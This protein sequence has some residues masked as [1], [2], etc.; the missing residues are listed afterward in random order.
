MPF[1]LTIL[2]AAAALLLGRRLALNPWTAGA[3]LGLL[4]C[5]LVV[6]L[7]HLV[8][9]TERLAALQ[10]LVALSAG[11]LLFGMV[12]EV[13]DWLED[14]NGMGEA[15][16]GLGYALFAGVA[17]FLAAYG[18]LPRANLVDA[19]GLFLISFG[20]LAPDPRPGV[21]TGRRVGSWCAALLVMAV[22][23]LLPSPP[24]SAGPLP[25][26]A[27]LLAVPLGLAKPS[28][29]LAG[30]TPFLAG[31][32]LLALATGLFRLI[33]P[34]LLGRWPRVPW[35]G[36]GTDLA[37]ALGLP[38]ASS[39]ALGSS[40][41][42]W[43]LAGVGL[44]VSRSGPESAPSSQSFWKAVPVRTKPAWRRR[45]PEWAGT[46]LATA[47]GLAVDPAAL[48]DGATWTLAGTFL[49]AAATARF[50]QATRQYRDDPDL[51]WRRVLPAGLVGLALMQVG[52]TFRN[53]YPGVRAAAFLA[54]VVLESLRPRPEP[55]PR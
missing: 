25:W 21:G 19:T 54:W 26:L 13:R 32:A 29:W 1:V 39:L 2:L 14:G 22:L 18:L 33:Q 23:A 11:P 43:V 53:Y 4:G 37:L 17:G 36:A 9:L 49:V 15:V 3:L 45:L 20:T 40:Y 46:L 34:R 6:H 16:P 35:L 48:G 38:A 50:F 27:R 5:G 8:S 41:P 12:L 30:A 55:Q 47:A 51:S 31:L 28:S 44:G 52:F 42:G 7:G 10:D 24:G